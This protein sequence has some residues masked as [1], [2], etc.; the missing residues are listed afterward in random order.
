MCCL[1]KEVRHPQ[2][3]EGSEWG[4]PRGGTSSLVCSG[5]IRQPSNADTPRS[6]WNRYSGKVKWVTGKGTQLNPPKM[7]HE[8]TGSPLLWRKDS[9]IYNVYSNDLLTEV[10]IPVGTWN[11]PGPFN[12]GVIQGQFLI[13]SW[14]TSAAEYISRTLSSDVDCPG[15]AKY[16]NVS[17]SLTSLR[18]KMCSFLK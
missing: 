9:A 11:G 16:F 5:G 8:L 14:T 7:A 18:K 1:L 3:G 4:L 6:L 12:L 17:P 15:N 10:S 13:I 2:V